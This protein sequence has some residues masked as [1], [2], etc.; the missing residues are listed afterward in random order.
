M[1][2]RVILALAVVAGLS[3]G[4]LRGMAVS[5]TPSWAPR[6]E[7][8]AAVSPGGDR[9]RPALEDGTHACFAGGC[10]WS[11]QARFEGGPGVEA[12]VAGTI[13]GREAVWVSFNPGVVHYRELVD[14][15]WRGIDPFATG[16]QF[17][18]LGESY[19]PAIYVTSGRMRDDAEASRRDVEAILGR[20]VS[21]PVL[22]GDA[23][24]PA[25]ERD[26]HYASRHRPQYAFYEWSCGRRAR[27]QE[28]WG[29]LHSLSPDR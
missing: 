7:T 17:C 5:W 21:V 14:H 4:W 23:F 3:Y 24:V 9:A 18:D 28:I 12:V 19:R 22:E 2:Q 15:Y 8:V 16:G 26:Q 29:L 13:D 10:F 25:P 11:T 27:L 6:M 1:S 20:R